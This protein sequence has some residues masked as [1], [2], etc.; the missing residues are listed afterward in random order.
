MQEF[1]RTQRWTALLAGQRRRLAVLGVPLLTL[2][3]LSDAQPVPIILAALI[4]QMALLFWATD[5][6]FPLRGGGSLSG[7]ASVQNREQIE[8]SFT[9]LPPGTHSAALA[10]S[11]DDARRL[12]EQHG[13][14]AVQALMTELGQ[15]LARVLREQDAFC[16]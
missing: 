6:V 9:S 10:V 7:C 1:T 2:I 3:A 15:R 13:E 14:R 4:V 16:R 11:L 5:G 12:T 8:A